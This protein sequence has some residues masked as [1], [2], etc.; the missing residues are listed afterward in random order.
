[1]FGVFLGGRGLAE[2]KSF[3]SNYVHCLQHVLMQPCAKL[4]CWNYF[5]GVYKYLCAEAQNTSPTNNLFL[6]EFCSLVD[7][8]CWCPAEKKTTLQ[9][10]NARRSCS[11]RHQSILR[12]GNH[13]KLQLQEFLRQHW[14]ITVQLWAREKTPFSLFQGVYQPLVCHFHQLSLYSHTYKILK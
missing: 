10:L 6:V 4:E 11:F 12:R 13:S 2:Q 14:N 3:C 7:W 1:M 8:R 5:A 9:H